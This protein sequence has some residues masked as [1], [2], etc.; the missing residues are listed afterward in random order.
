MGEMEIPYKNPGISAT[1]NQKWQTKQ[2]T[3]QYIGVH[4]DKR[5]NNWRVQLNLKGEKK[6]HGGFFKDE[7]NA[8]KRVNQLCEEF[9]I[10]YKN[11][12]IRTIKNQHVPNKDSKI[13]DPE[14]TNSVTNAE[15]S[16]AEHDNNKAN[17]N[18]RKHETDLIQNDNSV[19]EKYYFYENFLK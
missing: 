5:S 2:K 7:R 15:I 4:W 19:V 16:K 11:H 6:K 3:S 18:K 17:K 14:S 13:N 12:E 9:G 8:A 10:P 1:P